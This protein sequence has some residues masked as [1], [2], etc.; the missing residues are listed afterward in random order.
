MANIQ[1]ISSALDVSNQQANINSVIALVDG[2]VGLAG[3]TYVAAGVSNG[4]DTTDDVLATYTIPANYF[5]AGGQTLRFTAYGV[6][7]ATGNN[8]QIKIK[9]GT[10]T[11]LTSGTVTTN[12]GAWRI[13][14]DLAHISAN[15]QVGGGSGN[16]G[17]TPF[18]TSGAQTFTETGALTVTVTGASGTTGAAADVTLYGFTVEVLK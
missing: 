3:G 1:P 12:A 7:G 14:Y 17:A 16:S 15:V 6:T 2:A 9:I 5:T 4:A 18:A 13:V 11:V 10:T 8:K